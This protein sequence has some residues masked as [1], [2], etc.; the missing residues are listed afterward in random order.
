MPVFIASVDVRS[1][2]DEAPP[3]TNQ[4]A[5]ERRGIDPAVSLR[6]LETVAGTRETP[7]STQEP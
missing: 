1:A 2:F 4:Q 7:S 5:L 3:H 6:L